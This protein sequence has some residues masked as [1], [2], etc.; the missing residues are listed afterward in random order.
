MKSRHIFYLYGSACHA[1]KGSRSKGDKKVA[2][3]D[4]RLEMTKSRHQS[5][6]FSRFAPGVSCFQS[7]FPIPSLVLLQSQNADS[8]P[9]YC[10]LGTSP[11]RIQTQDI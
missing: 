9:N 8:I 7:L 3:S 11:H 5:A 2:K 1:N 6:F 4:R 10:A